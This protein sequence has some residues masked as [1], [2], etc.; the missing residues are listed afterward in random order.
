MDFYEFMYGQLFVF[1]ALLLVTLFCFTLIGKINLKG[2]LKDKRNQKSSP[3]RIQLLV[4]TITGAGMYLM[5]VLSSQNVDSGMLPPV[6]SDLLAILGGSNVV[7]L[8]GKFLSAT[9]SWSKRK[10]KP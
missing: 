8:S 4:L 7:Y 9:R 1:L 5:E 10:L 3:G 2:L 6:S